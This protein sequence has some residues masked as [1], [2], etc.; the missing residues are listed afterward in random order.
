[1]SNCYFNPSLRNVVPKLQPPALQ[2]HC[3]V[4]MSQVLERN[5]PIY[6][7]NHIPLPAKICILLMFTELLP[8]TV[9]FSSNPLRFPARRCV[10]CHSVLNF[11]FKWIITRHKTSVWCFSFRTQ[12][13][14]DSWWQKCKAKPPHSKNI[15]TCPCLFACLWLLCVCFTASPHFATKL[16]APCLIWRLLFC[17]GLKV[18]QG[19]SSLYRQGSESE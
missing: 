11:K 18:F 6:C 15:P 10:C 12:S 16:R 1:M 13:R 8:L 2:T 17:L 7:Y 9:M 5:Q 3:I 19:E 4:F 14:H